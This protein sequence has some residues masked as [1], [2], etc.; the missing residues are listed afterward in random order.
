MIVSLAEARQQ[1]RADPSGS[2]DE[3]IALYIGAA[4]GRIRNYLNREIP[5]TEESPIAVPSDIKAAALMMIAGM[6]EIREDTITG[7]TVADNPAVVNLLFPYRV[8]MG[9]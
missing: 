1:C 6:Y 2:D 4:E 8:N 7:T 3:L 5:G 9:V